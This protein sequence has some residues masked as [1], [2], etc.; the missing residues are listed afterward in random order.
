MTEMLSAVEFPHWL[1]IAGAVL[2]VLGFFGF[3][4]SQDKNLPPDDQKPG[5]MKANGK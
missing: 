2:V 1:L 5:G 4:F 3:A